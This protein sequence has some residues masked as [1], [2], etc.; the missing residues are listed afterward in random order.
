MG[1]MVA[2]LGGLLGAGCPGPDGGPDPT[3]RARAGMVDRQ[4][5]ARGVKDA[6]VLEVMRQV[7]RHLFVPAEQ[8]ALAY[9]DHPLPIGSGQTISQP[10]VVAF[11]TEQLRL[12]GTERV[13]EIGTG[14]GYQAAVL[15]RLASRVYTIEIRPELAAEATERLKA[16]GAGN[17]EVRTAD[18]FYGW[19]EEAPFDGILVTAAPEKIPEPLLAQLAPGGRMV[20]PVGGFYQELKVIERTPGGLVERSVLPVR[21]VPFVGEAERHR[22]GETPR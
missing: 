8:V 22:P 2:L 3:A 10:Y 21:F 16:F 6:R 5:V 7:P 4:I 20:I 12:T 11:M 19:P 18:G 1:L 15:S 17:V 13:L 9:D 14:S